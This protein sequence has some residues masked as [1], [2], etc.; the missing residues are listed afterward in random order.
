MCGYRLGW[1]AGE[2]LEMEEELH[3][4]HLYLGGNSGNQE[5]PRLIIMVILH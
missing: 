4:F 3:Q 2:S 5:R 1:L